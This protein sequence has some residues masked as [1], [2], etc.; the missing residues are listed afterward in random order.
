LGFESNYWQ[1]P[2][3]DVI[4]QSPDYSENFAFLERKV[5]F[6]GINLVGGIVHDQAEWNARH[7]ANLLWIDTA[8]AK[9]DGQYTTMV[10]FAHADPLIEINNNFFADFYSMVER[11]DEQVIFVHRNLGIDT[12]KR[13]SGYNGVPNLEVV[14]VEGSK[15]PPMW[16]QID[17]R[18]GAY[19]IDQSS[20]YDEYMKK[21]TMPF[22][23]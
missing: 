23:P 16:M 22:S 20:W 15:W 4:R 19:S 12:W 10:V 3:W 8:A 1:E 17:S 14:A 18:S 13:E 6:V 5:L 11:Y 7:Q 9:Y 2:S 21:G